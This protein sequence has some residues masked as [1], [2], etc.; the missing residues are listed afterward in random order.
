MWDVDPLLGNDRETRN[1]TTAVA[2]Q[3]LNSDHVETPTDTKA[4][5]SQ[6]EMKGV[7]CAFGAEIL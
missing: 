4:T 1:Y 5:M 7:F 3:W 2:R 6:Q